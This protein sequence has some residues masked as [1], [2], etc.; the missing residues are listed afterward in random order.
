MRKFSVL[1]TLLLMALLLHMPKSVLADGTKLE[2]VLT[3]AA[4]NH[5]TPQGRAE[6]E[7]KDSNRREF[8][9]DVQNVNLADGTMLNVSVNTTSLGTLTLQ[10]GSGELGF[11]TDDGDTVPTM[12][13]GDVISVTDSTGATILSGTLGG[14]QNVHLSAN[15]SGKPIHK[16]TPT[17]QADFQSNGTRSQFQIEIEK[18]RLPN[19]TQLSVQVNGNAF[20]TLS[21]RHGRASLSLDSQNGDTIPAMAAG[22]VLTVV[23]ANGNII[24]SGT[25][26]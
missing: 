19:K 25:L 24:L 10:G 14:N 12:Q 4:I 23:D 3:G 2:A 6:F 22:D 11:K 9:L 1:A 15:L 20:G 13:S 16:V 17:G 5:V 18:V 21:L 7:S 26:S 8:R